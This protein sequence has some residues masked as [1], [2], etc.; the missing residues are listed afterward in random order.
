LVPDGTCPG[1]L[2]LLKERCRCAGA[3][4]SR[5]PTG[6]V[7]AGRGGLTNVLVPPLRHES[8]QRWARCMAPTDRAKR[9][10]A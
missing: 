1:Q 6:C 9:T 3:D 2:T 7:P 8:Q 5:G 10:H 4:S